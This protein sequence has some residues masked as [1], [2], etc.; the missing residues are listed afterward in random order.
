MD[1]DH[2]YEHALKW[3]Y[4]AGDL[5][6]KSISQSIKVEYKTSMADL[7]TEKDR[8][9]EAFFV[10]KIN[11]TYEAHYIVGEEGIASQ[12][13]YNPEEETVWFIDPI[14]G[15]TNFVHQ[16]QAFC[17]SVAV[18][19][20]G[21]PLFGI[22]YDPM[23]NECFRARSGQGAYLNNQ[24]LK[25]LSNLDIGEAV[26]GINSLW[27]TPNKYDDHS[28]YQALVKDVRGARSIGSAALEI[29]Y[30]ACDRLD[31]YVTMRLSPWDFA[32]GLV[33]LKEVGGVASTITLEDI[34]VFKNS[35]LYVAKP[36]LHEKIGNKYLS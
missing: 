9:V 23:A 18:Y 21:E 22:I 27:L 11:D 30:V 33:I 32:A 4:E 35:S 8:E 34:N 25:P 24:P 36:G 17:I 19:Q 3:V 7:V 26:I 15:T 20:Q 28:K 5:L 14:D 16:K 6:K 12:G 29:A 10:Q 31:A 2:I 1:K 13:N